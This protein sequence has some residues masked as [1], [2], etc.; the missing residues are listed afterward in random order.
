MSGLPRA[1]TERVRAVTSAG[2]A[3]VIAITGADLEWRFVTE[4]YRRPS[5]KLASQQV[6]PIVGAIT[7][8]ASITSV[9]IAIRRPSSST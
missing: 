4:N 5:T 3:A 1:F 8:D 7:G 9:T 2:A 6:A